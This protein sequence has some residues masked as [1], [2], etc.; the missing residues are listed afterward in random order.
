M[1]GVEEWV[2]NLMKETYEQY[3]TH[4]VGKILEEIGELSDGEKWVLFDKLL[5]R[6]DILRQMCEEGRP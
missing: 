4:R 2:E 3:N 1:S 6:E 5:D